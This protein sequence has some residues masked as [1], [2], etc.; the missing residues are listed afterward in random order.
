MNNTVIAAIVALV[1]GFGGAWLFGQVG[2]SSA[3]T[4]E[5]EGTGDADLLR[6]Q[7]ADLKRELQAIKNPPET[8]SASAPAGVRG[9]ASEEAVVEAVLAKLDERVDARVEKKFESMAASEDEGVSIRTGSGR[10]GGRKRV[11]LE[12]A[13]RELELSAA[14][15]DELRRIYDESLNKFMKLAA[16]PDGDV[17][18]VKRDLEQMRKDPASARTLMMKYVPNMMSNIGKVM[19]ISTERQAAVEKAIGVDKARRLNSEFD[20][21]EANPM[22]GNFRIGASMGADMPRDR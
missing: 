18:D 19:S 16:G 12:D 13:A 9:G 8:L 1:A 22:G 14:E 7:I 4:G 10:R 15:E 5:A 21:I 6:E 11:S 20:V 3:A 17:E 2:G